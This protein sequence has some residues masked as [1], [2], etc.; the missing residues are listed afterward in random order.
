MNPIKIYFVQ[1]GKGERG[2]WRGGFG[3]HVAPASKKSQDP[4]V[5][6]GTRLLIHANKIV[7]IV[8]CHPS[9]F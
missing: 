2:I 4:K 8:K 1:K 5:V 9:L 3:Q 6:F 7:V